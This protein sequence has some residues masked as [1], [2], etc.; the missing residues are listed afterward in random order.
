[1]AG[2]KRVMSVAEKK[3]EGGLKRDMHATCLLPLKL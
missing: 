2:G 1:M 3:D